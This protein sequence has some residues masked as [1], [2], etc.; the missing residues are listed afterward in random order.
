[1]VYYT[2]FAS[3]SVV[4]IEQLTQLFQVEYCFVYN[5]RIL[6]DSTQAVK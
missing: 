2:E 4:V 5:I 1:M 3:F 6:A